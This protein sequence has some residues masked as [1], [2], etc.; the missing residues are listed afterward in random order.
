MDA[1]DEEK[2]KEKKGQPVTLTLPVPPGRYQPQ[3]LGDDS[4]ICIPSRDTIGLDK[5]NVGFSDASGFALFD[6][7]FIMDVSGS[8]AKVLQELEHKDCSSF[9]V[10]PDNEFIYTVSG[11]CCCIWKIHQNEVTLSEKIDFNFEKDVTCIPKIFPSKDNQHLIGFA[12]EPRKEFFVFN[13]VTKKT[14]VVADD[15][16][17]SSLNFSLLE[18]EDRVALL[19]VKPV[20]GKL[21]YFEINFSA[22]KMISDHPTKVMKIP[23]IRGCETSPNGNY[24]AYYDDTNLTVVDVISGK[25]RMLNADVS[26]TANSLAY[27]DD[28]QTLACVLVKSRDEYNNALDH[29]IILVDLNSPEF[30]T[31]KCPILTGYD[32]FT[33]LTL[34]P[35]PSGIL[36]V[37]GNQC[38]RVIT[39]P[40]YQL[41][42]EVLKEAKEAI[43]QYYLYGSLPKFSSPLIKI[44]SN[45]AD[46]SPDIKF[47]FFNE[48]TSPR[49]TERE[50][51][52]GILDKII[53]LGQFTTHDRLALQTFLVES[54]KKPEKLLA[55]CKK[56]ALEK[57]TKPGGRSP[58]TSYVSKFLD[59]LEK[60]DTPKKALEPPKA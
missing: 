10:S 33:P 53:R 18:S 41:I 49:L 2:D 58:L 23:Y 38:A 50:F 27:L 54:A 46:H 25:K 52:N 48:K 36:E 14:T 51:L 39:H 31:E 17:D 20:T 30:K 59:Q 3:S 6:S 7:V 16:K 24:F 21:A 15:R 37:A 4:R 43:L 45:L 34:S 47:G 11:G 29:D 13:L 57:V 35:I 26:R 12:S 8:E 40:D 42:K 55:D 32:P 5:D 22:D 60:L 56:A 28:G 19:C 9:G 1:R 44:T